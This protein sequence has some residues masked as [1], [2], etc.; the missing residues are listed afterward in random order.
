MTL[1]SVGAGGSTSRDWFDPSGLMAAAGP[2]VAVGRMGGSGWPRTDGGGIGVKGAGD[3][4][5][6]PG[7]SGS[8]ATGN[9]GAILG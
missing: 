4:G 6:F 1:S 5:D 7:W 2:F 3:F 8:G 9:A